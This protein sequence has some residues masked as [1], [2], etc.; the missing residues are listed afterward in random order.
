MVLVTMSLSACIGAFYGG[1]IRNWFIDWQSL[2][3]PPERGIRITADDRG[4]PLVETA[5]GAVYLTL[6]LN[7]P[8]SCVPPVDFY[9]PRPPGQVSSTVEFQQCEPGMMLVVGQY[10][11]ALLTD[12][13]VWR[14]HTT[15]AGL[16]TVIPNTLLGLFVGLNAG[17][18]MSLIIHWFLTRRLIRSVP[19]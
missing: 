18:V 14:W 19:E 7:A 8:S 13:S 3:Q 9:V 15:Y 4:W 16:L 2:G 10:N 17:F 11:F 1:T 6:P 5:T 12:G